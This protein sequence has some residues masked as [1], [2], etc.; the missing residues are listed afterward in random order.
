LIFAYSQCHAA[1]VLAAI[2]DTQQLLHSIASTLAAVRLNVDDDVP[3][4]DIGT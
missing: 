2:L 4:F 3:D 1:K